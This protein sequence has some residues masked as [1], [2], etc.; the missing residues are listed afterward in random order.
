MSA[1]LVFK[2][3]MQWDQNAIERKVFMKRKICPDCVGC[4]EET[5][6]ICSKGMCRI[7]C[8]TGQRGNA[9]GCGAQRARAK[10]RTESDKNKTEKYSEKSAVSPLSL[11]V[12]PLVCCCPGV[13]ALHCSTSEHV[14]DQ[15]RC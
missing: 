14:T 5:C 6:T 3:D 10:Y 13:M 7:W 9:M 15:L 8:P 4:V 2:A 12:L 11:W 1:Q